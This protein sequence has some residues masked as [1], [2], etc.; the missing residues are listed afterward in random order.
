[1]AASEEELRILRKAFSDICRGY[2]ADVLFSGTAFV[3]HLSHHDQ[4]DLDIVYKEFLEKAKK[5]SIPEHAEVFQTLSENDIWTNKDELQITKQREYINHLYEGKKH[6]YLKSKI[7]EHGRIIKQEERKLADLI[8]KKASLFGVTAEVYAE[9]KMNEVYIVKSIFKDREC[10]QP[11]F[12][13]EQIEDISE[14]ELKEIVAFYNKITNSLEE[15]QIR[16]IVLQDFFLTYWRGCDNNLFNFFGK[17]ICDISLLQI[18]L[19]SYAKMFS[20]IL[21][22][23]NNIPEDIRYD[24]DKLIDYANASSKGQE[25]LEK[26]NRENAA[27]SLVGAKKED[28]ENMGYNDQNS[29][30]LSQK[31][32]EKQQKSGNKSEGL[33]MHDLMEMMGAG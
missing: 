21:E 31:I 32:K 23:T 30:S 1:M 28:Y 2:S 10:L 22:N 7:E 33:N 25:N 26:Y 3:K 8:N 20:N 13:D 27:T 6:L 4:I 18:K 5:R 29:V 15:S 19:G 11:L 9:R 16:K 14:E 17:P 12:Y 24:P